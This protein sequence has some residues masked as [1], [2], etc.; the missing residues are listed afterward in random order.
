LWEAFL[1][2][3]NDFDRLLEHKLR[4]MLDPVVATPAPPRR[5]RP[6]KSRRP[7]LMVET[8]SRAVVV[9]AIPVI[10]AVP[11]PSIRLHP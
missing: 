6:T 8:G 3:M 2:H 5:E 9:E 10:V 7:L 11:A 1:V 4:Q